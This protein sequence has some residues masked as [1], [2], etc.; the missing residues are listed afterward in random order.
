[1]NQNTAILDSEKDKLFV[2]K[3]LNRDKVRWEK[4]KA[5]CYTNGISGISKENSDLIIQYLKDM[6]TGLNVSVENSK[7]PR[8]PRRLNDLKDKMTIF[9]KKFE[10][11]YHVTNLANLDEGKV[12]NLFYG[13]QQG[14]LKTKAGVN[15]KSIDTFVKSFKSFW[16]WHMKANRKKKIIIEDITQDLDVKGE[17]PDWVYLTE[18]QVRQLADSMSFNYKVLIMFLLDTGIRSPLE[19]LQ[20]KVSDLY[21]DCKELNIRICKKHSFPRKIKLML[22]SELLKTYIQTQ[23]K[24]PD[25]YLFP[26]CPEVVN[27]NLKKAVVKLF[28]DVTSLAGHKYSQITMYDFRHNACCYWLPRYKSES[29]LKYRFGWKKTDKIHYYSELL[30][31]SDTISEGDLLIDV[32][33]TELEN[34]MKKVEYENSL[35]KDKVLEFEKYMKKIDELSKRIEVTIS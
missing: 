9:S 34:R 22:C 24:K 16:H 29:A 33:K 2:E 26:V 20:V 32:T 27:R 6:E 18:T 23:N 35:L 13:M 7:G 3:R 31:M 28:G 1:M 19:L 4:W 17:K 14:D 10:Q 8:S 25:D 15:Y 12:F 21:D 30:G 11:L 5:N